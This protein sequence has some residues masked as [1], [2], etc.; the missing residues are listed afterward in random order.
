MWR[1]QRGREGSFG[2]VGEERVPPGG[3]ACGFMSMG[4]DPIEITFPIP[5]RVSFLFWE[6]IKFIPFPSSCDILHSHSSPTWPIF[7]V[8]WFSYFWNHMFSGEWSLTLS[9]IL[10][11]LNDG[12]YT[13]VASFLR[14]LPSFHPPI[15]IPNCPIWIPKKSS[16][17]LVK[18][19]TKLLIQTRVP[20]LY[21][22]LESKVPF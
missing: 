13:W 18:L 15:D 16:S 9:G 12:E 4:W 11:D 7:V 22:H 2:G 19:F 17:L 6:I 3:L 1:V 8:L 14:Q 5:I 21:I 10:R 20:S